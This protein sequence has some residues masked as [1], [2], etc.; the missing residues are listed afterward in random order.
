MKKPNIIVISTIILNLLV[1]SCG[2]VKITPVITAPPA[3]ANLQ[4]SPSPSP[5][6]SPAL[7][8]TPTP[9][10][11]PTILPAQLPGGAS[12]PLKT[13]C[14]NVS[15]SGDTTREPVASAIE[16]TLTR[17]GFTVLQTGG[18]CDATLYIQMSF[19]AIGA[20]YASATKSCF[21]YSSA[22]ME[23][24]ASFTV[25]G[26][27]PLTFRL[28]NSTGLWE[29]IYGCDEP[30][31]GMAPFGA[32]WGYPINQVLSHIWGLP[33]LV[34][35]LGVEPLWNHANLR[36]N[37]D[38]SPET[39]TAIVQALIRALSDSSPDVRREA[40]TTLADFTSQEAMTMPYLIPLLSDPDDQVRSA[41]TDTLGKFGPAAAPAVP[42]LIAMIND[43]SWT[44]GEKAI[45]TLGKIGP[46]A[47]AAVPDLIEIAKNQNS[48]L[49]PAAVEALGNIGPAAAE[50]APYL[51]AILEGSD[52]SEYG[53]K[54]RAAAAKSMDQVGAD[55]QPALAKLGELAKSTDPGTQQTAVNLL[56][57]M[58]P[59]VPEVIPYLIP[60]IEVNG[61][62]GYSEVEGQAI[63]ALGR[64]GSAAKDALP[65]LRTIAADDSPDPFR[66]YAL[67]ALVKIG[68]IPT[69][70]ATAS[71][72]AILHSGVPSTY[73]RACFALG[74]LG[75]QVADTAVPEL[76][77]TLTQQLGDST[78]ASGSMF[79]TTWAL[80]QMG[81]KAASAIA[82]LMSMFSDQTG[83]FSSNY[84]YA[85]MA[86]GN[87]GPA[88]RQAV[89][90]IIE[91]LKAE[92][93]QYAIDAE[94][95]ALKQITGQDFGADAGQWEAWWQAQ[96]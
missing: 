21:D 79:A 41:A 71:L 36:P 2:Q 11:A 56:V 89:P 9:L 28:T 69:S 47:A 86:L 87:I 64:F 22:S 38:M 81:E 16:Q 58:S 78:T 3:T 52:T 70:Q 65:D 32:I 68:D 83:S 29:V 6:L 1:Q 76:I 73:E 42:A 17:A 80:G 74:E 63:F 54:L 85:V 50:A 20:Q 91:K 44:T 82:I 61:E 15:Q 25:P 43:E 30:T 57:A 53:N 35:T 94:V 45:Q 39:M 27:E 24:Q 51:L 96:K 26:N 48:L 92:T 5:L 8:Q 46:G 77:Q 40:A 60:L 12:L 59:D 14:L 23:G 4:A 75:P 7:F 18:A 37:K 34:Y 95:T 88:A 67:A 62:Y 93:A 10:P 90:Q 55:L 31:P 49:C 13:I 84:F 72:F 66:P 19:T 33:V